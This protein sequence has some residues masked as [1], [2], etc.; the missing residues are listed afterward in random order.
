MSI[1]DLFD[2]IFRRKP[3][4]E[5]R[6]HTRKPS[7]AAH[8]IAKAIQ[9]GQDINATP[10]RIAENAEDDLHTA[11]FRIFSTKIEREW[12]HITLQKLRELRTA[13]HSVEDA[14][15][16]AAEHLADF[17]NAMG[18]PEIVDEWWALAA[19]VADHNARA[20]AA[21]ARETRDE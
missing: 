9:K 17:L 13:G 21:A 6:F 11:G 2:Q 10:A 3:D 4:Q 14:N 15:F 7:F 19:R 16:Y 12:K 8:V 5:S 1:A 20:K 18:H